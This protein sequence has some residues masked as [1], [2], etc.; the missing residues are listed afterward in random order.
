MLLMWKPVR[1]QGAGA[2]SSIINANAIPA[3]KLLDPWRR[4]VNCLFGLSLAG[5][6][7]T[8]TSGA[9][10]YDPTGA[11]SCPDTGWNYFNG[12]PN[13]PQIDR[14]PL[15]AT[16]GWDATQNGNLAEQLQEPSLMG[17][18]EG[19]GITVLGK[20]VD[21]HGLN[22]WSDGNEGGAFPTGTTLLT[23]VGPDPTA[24]A[25]GDANP[26]CRTQKR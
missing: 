4:H 10:S 23:G 22:P 13:A 21:F 16:V 5:V 20:G 18:Y 6:P 25:T 2:V 8:T 14:L 19:A 11:F 15:E 1:L 7:T 12:L 9:G 24:L 17:A 3:G 26:L